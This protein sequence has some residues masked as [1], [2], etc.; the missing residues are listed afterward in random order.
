MLSDGDEDGDGSIDFDEFV[1][2]MAHTLHSD[3]PTVNDAQPLVADGNGEAVPVA[4][5]KKVVE[6]QATTGCV[7]VEVLP[8]ISTG[9][10]AAIAVLDISSLSATYKDD[11]DT[12]MV[13]LRLANIGVRRGGV[14]APEQ[15]AS[16]S[17]NVISVAPRSGDDHGTPRG[18]DTNDLVRVHM[19]LRGDED[20]EPSQIEVALHG[21]RVEVEPDFVAEL[22]RF[23]AENPLQRQD[24]ASLSDAAGAAAVAAGQAANEALVEEE[25][26]DTHIQLR[27]DDIVLLLA[28]LEPQIQDTLTT[29]ASAGM[30]APTAR[31][32]RA[33]SAEFHLG[34]LELRSSNHQKSVSFSDVRLH[35]ARGNTTH[36]L[37]QPLCGKLNLLQST[38]GRQVVT[39]DDLHSI[40]VTVSFRDVCALNAVA[41]SFVEVL[42]KNSAATES[43]SEDAIT[44]WCLD[45]DAALEDKLDA[46][47]QPEVEPQAEPQSDTGSGAPLLSLLRDEGIVIRVTFYDDSQHSKLNAKPVLALALSVN[48]LAFLRFA[49]EDK[50]SVQLQAAVRGHQING[51]VVP[52]LETVSVRIEYAKQLAAGA[53]GVPVTTGGFVACTTASV[54][55]ENAL[56][57]TVTQHYLENIL[58]MLPRWLRIWS[59]SEH[60]S[61]DLPAFCLKNETGNDI[62]SE[63]PKG[64]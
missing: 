24:I 33:S 1:A 26:K 43:V 12:K 47:S 30:E 16:A 15:S 3:H 57:F 32:N 60:G 35:L 50:L 56:E 64:G 7:S 46:K 44:D 59:A 45:E 58:T 4:D 28:S 21:L 62:R 2:M 22:V 53:G 5:A 51:A 25:K 36:D 39:I 14:L 49:D 54:S 13:D 11:G 34:H 55:L 31:R 42:P 18:G 37:L 20:S 9:R 52:L 48:S 19:M 41:Q 6:V 17:D 27:V 38:E 40:E 61:P 23:G 10:E 63:P 8:E 29:A